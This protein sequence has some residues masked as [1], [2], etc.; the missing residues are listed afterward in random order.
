VELPASLPRDGA[1]ELF[2][3]RDLAAENGALKLSEA[4]AILPFAV[5]TNQ[6]AWKTLS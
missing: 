6:G 4:M 1:R 5:Y 2:S 3:G